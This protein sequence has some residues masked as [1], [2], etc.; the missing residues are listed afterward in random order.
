M[1]FKGRPRA[2]KRF[3]FGEDTGFG[4]V[5]GLPTSQR[6]PDY[7]LTSGSIKKR[8]SFIKCTS[9][10]SRNYEFSSKRKATKILGVAIDP[11]C[12]YLWRLERTEPT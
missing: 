1:T 10:V 12:I 6:H 5:G 7:K 2:Y 8:V 9:A 3:G 4:L 11:T